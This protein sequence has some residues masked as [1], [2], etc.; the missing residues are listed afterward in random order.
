MLQKRLISLQNWQAAPIMAARLARKTVPM[1]SEERAQEIAGNALGFVA[2]DRAMIQALL[3]VSGLD[4][5]DLRQ[6]AERPEFAIFLL[7][8]VLLDDDRVLA[9]AASQ[10]IKPEAVLFA[11]ET[12]ANLGAGVRHG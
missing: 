1:L 6:A 5:A 8:F 10:G 11:R 12:L 2:S 3:D 4:L 9:F 7:D